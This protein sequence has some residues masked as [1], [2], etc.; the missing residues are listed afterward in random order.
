MTRTALRASR[1]PQS[2]DHL[3]A[4]YDRF[5][6]LVGGEL[7]AWLAFRLPARG[8]RALDAGSGTGVH[9]ALLADRFDDVLAVD[10]SEPMVDHA[11][12]H[13]PRGNVRYEVRDLHDLT[14]ERDGTFDLVLCAYTLHHV[15]D[16]RTALEHLH[17][18]IR[19]GGTLLVI[20]V[21]DARRQVPRSWLRAEA[22][23]TFGGDL[24]HR[25]RP[26]REAVELLRLQLDRDW[27]DHQTTDRLWPPDDWDDNA[28]AVLPG[29]E[30]SPLYRARALR[31]RAP[32]RDLT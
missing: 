26:A 1:D 21:V 30:I 27:L 12:S 28:R 6:E 31:W 9:T 5:A 20:D 19:P 22:L 25:R 3:P 8:G 16:L 24:L 13:Q 10:L 32:D 17:G 7:R 14:R 29:A 23:R 15:P 11:R 18:L 2:F 4:R